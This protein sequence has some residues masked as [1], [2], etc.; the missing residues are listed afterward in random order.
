M[1]SGREDALFTEPAD[2]GNSEPLCGK[3]FGQLR[4]PTCVVTS[5]LKKIKELSEKKVEVDKERHKTS[6]WIDMVKNPGGN[7]GRTGAQ[8]LKTL[9]KEGGG[10]RE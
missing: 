6:H 5:I 4:K 3:E 2:N 9:E 1:R 7:H 8:A 10:E